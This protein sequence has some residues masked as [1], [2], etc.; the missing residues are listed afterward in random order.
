M[1]GR[2]HRAAVPRPPQRPLRDGGDGERQPFLIHPIS[3]KNGLI[4]SRTV[5]AVR[6]HKQAEGEEAWALFDRDQHHDIPKAL[7]EAA[8]ANIQVC[9]SHPSF[10]LWLLLHFQAMSGRQSGSSKEVV[11]KLRAAHPAYK[12]FD[13]KNDKS[14]GSALT[15]CCL[16]SPCFGSTPVQCGLTGSRIVRRVRASTPSTQGCLRGFRSPV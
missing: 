9:F 12:S 5:A 3:A 2:G 13:V 6:D 10:D 7:K 8:E 1:R 16:R 4:P 11:K 15:T 14:A